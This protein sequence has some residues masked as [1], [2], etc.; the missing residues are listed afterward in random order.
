MSLQVNQ[1]AAEGGVVA[2]LEKT[3]DA[4]LQVISG[5]AVVP[6]KCFL[7]GGST[8]DKTLQGFDVTRSDY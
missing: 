2:V 6:G 7:T 8:F 3:P 5:K 4:E 1:L